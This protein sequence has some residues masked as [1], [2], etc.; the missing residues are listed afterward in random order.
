[1]DRLREVNHEVKL[2]KC[3]F[4]RQSVE[5]LEHVLTPQG[6]QPNP[7]Q[8]SAVKAFSVPQN[9]SELCQFLG[10]TSYNQKFIAKFA[11][12]ALP[13]HQLTRKEV[14]W[15]WTQEC[16][17]AVDLQKGKLVS[18]PALVYPDFDHDFV[19]ETDACVKGLGAILSQS[20]PDKRLPPIVLR[21]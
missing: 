21:K 1:M 20:K 8:V 4:I 19:L 16:Q 17:D 6:L 10:V 3:S 7:R 15:N 2:T 18:S 11:N 5:F 13:L 9:V 14:K 12:V